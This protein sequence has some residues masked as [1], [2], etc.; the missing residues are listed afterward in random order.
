[1]TETMT[2]YSIDTSATMTELYLDVPVVVVD[3]WVTTGGAVNVTVQS[4]DGSQAFSHNSYSG[5][6]G[7]TTKRSSYAYTTLDKLQNVEVI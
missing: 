1:M 5:G 2:A 4:V 6:E 3:S 7:Y